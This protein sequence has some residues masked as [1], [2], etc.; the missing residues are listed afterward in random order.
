VERYPFSGKERM[1]GGT[2]TI[3][4]GVATHV[5]GGSKDALLHAADAALYTAKREGRNRVCMAE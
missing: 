1:P 5:P 2:L 3:S 4:I